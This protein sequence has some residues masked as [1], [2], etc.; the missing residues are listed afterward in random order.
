MSSSVNCQTLVTHFQAKKIPETDF[1]GNDGVVFCTKGRC[2]NNHLASL[3]HI[4]GHSSSDTTR[5]WLV[6]EFQV[7]FGSWLE[8]AGAELWLKILY[9]VYTSSSQAADLHV[10]CF[11]RSPPWCMFP[12]SQESH[13]LVHCKCYETVILLVEHLNSSV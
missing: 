13:L 12:L 1:Q 2:V 11:T 9:A 8:P 10:C 7:C 5:L 4:K 6:A 3:G